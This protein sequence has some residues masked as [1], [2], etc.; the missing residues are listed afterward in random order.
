MAYKMNI[1]N[2]L[3]QAKY[4]ETIDELAQFCADHNFQCFDAAVFFNQA[5]RVQGHYEDDDVYVEF[6]VMSKY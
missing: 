3:A 6:T 4:C 1:G 2:E 5:P